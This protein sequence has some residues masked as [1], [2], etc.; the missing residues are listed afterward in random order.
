MEKLAKLAALSCL[1]AENAKNDIEKILEMAE[2]LR[3]VDNEEYA[4]DGQGI[5]RND[6]ECEC[7]APIIE[8]YIIVPK[9]VGE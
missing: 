6:E 9:V 8:G 1:D 4:S 7:D 3:E 5:L 2:I